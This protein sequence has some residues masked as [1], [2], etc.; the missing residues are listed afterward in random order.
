M[1]GILGKKIGMTQ[2]YSAKGDCVAVTV[3]HVERCVPILNRSKEKNGYEA[4]LVGYGERKAK[5]VNKPMKGFFDKNKVSPTHSLR[6]FRGQKVAD[7]ALGKPMNVEIFQPGDVVNVV[8]VSKGRGF[9]GVIKRHGFSGMP[10]SRGTHESFRGGGSIGMHTYPGRV[11]KG[12]PMPGH[13]GCDRVQIK[14]L[15]VVQVDKDKNVLLIGGAVP[16]ANGGI[17][18]VVKARKKK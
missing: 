12:K 6:E 14:N 10:A 1:N 3:I 8:G 16:G 2:I 4:V 11:R 13:M 15:R 9:A 18:R 7:D 17:V 5:R